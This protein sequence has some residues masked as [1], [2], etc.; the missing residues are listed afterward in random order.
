MYLLLITI[1][2]ASGWTVLTTVDELR[3]NE[4]A[5]QETAM[6]LSSNFLF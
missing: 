5:R 1:N 3:L 6:V 4:S 2:N